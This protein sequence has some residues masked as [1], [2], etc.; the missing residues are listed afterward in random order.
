ML[1]VVFQV[2]YQCLETLAPS[3]MMEISLSKRLKELRDK[4]GENSMLYTEDIEIEA[5]D[6]DVF[7]DY[8]E[9]MMQYGFVTLFA[10]AFPLAPLCAFFNNVAEIRSDAFKLCTVSARPTPKPTPNI[11][12]W[13]T[14]LQALTIVGVFTN[15]AIIFFTSHEMERWDNDITLQERIIYF[16]IIEQ[17]VLLG[18]WAIQHVIPDVPQNI[19]DDIARQEYIRDLQRQQALGTPLKKDQAQGLATLSPPEGSEGNRARAYKLE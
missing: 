8:L 14:V 4:Y 3:I 1:L 10:A 19:Q 11:G 18:I 12:A 7:E 15:F 6:Y 13:L 5:S 17:S 9:M 2:V 16:L